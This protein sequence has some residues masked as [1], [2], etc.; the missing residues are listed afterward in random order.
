MAKYFIFHVYHHA[1]IIHFLF[2]PKW[3]IVKQVLFSLCPID[4][5][6]LGHLFMS[7]SFPHAKMQPHL[8]SSHLIMI[9]QSFCPERNL[10]KEAQARHI[11]MSCSFE[12]SF[13]SSNHSLPPKLSSCHASMWAQ[14]QIF[15]SAQNF[16][17]WSKYIL[18]CSIMAANISR[19][20]SIHITSHHQVV[21]QSLWP[22]ALWNFSKFLVRINLSK[23]SAILVHPNNMKLFEHLHIF[24][25]LGH[26]QFQLNLHLHVSAT[27]SSLILAIIVVST[28]S[29]I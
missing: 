28:A 20:S 21:S 3:H 14:L 24:K 8:P 2:C 18:S 10:V 7:I 25:S 22:F 9:F 6:L 19:T 13:I 1:Q 5:K 26:A 16:R 4:L 27:S 29:T 23:A 17:L 11:Q 12:W 15:V